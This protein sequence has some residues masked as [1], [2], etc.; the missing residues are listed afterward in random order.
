MLNGGALWNVSWSLVTSL[1]ATLSELEIPLDVVTG[2]H[3]TEDR[4][5]WPWDPGRGPVNGFVAE[6]A[7]NKNKA[8]ENR[9]KTAEKVIEFLCLR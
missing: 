9:N 6:K 2:T 3:L 7:K 4:A 8:E 5:V 1:L